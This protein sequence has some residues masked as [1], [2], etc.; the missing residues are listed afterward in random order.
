[1]EKTA[2][3]LRRATIEDY[4]FWKKLFENINNEIMYR[5]EKA[6]SPEEITDEYLKEKA[7]INPETREIIDFCLPDTTEAVFE[8]M[9]TEWKDKIYIIELY[10]SSNQKVKSIGYFQV[11]H[12]NKSE[13]NRITSWAMFPKYFTRKHEAFKL[14][15]EQKEMKGKEISTISLECDCFR[16]WI[17]QF[18]FKEK[19]DDVLGRMYLAN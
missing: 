8:S 17:V 3:R 4:G 19:E 6:F 16:Y 12:V 14:L 1:M 9:I 13:K 10:K 2:V 18:G 5:N 7:E 15:L 11:E